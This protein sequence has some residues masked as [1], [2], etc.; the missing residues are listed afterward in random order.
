MIQKYLKTHP[1]KKM[2]LYIVPIGGVLIL[3]LFWFSFLNRSI[4][5]TETLPVAENP[6]PYPTQAITIKT[7]FN[8]S[9][10]IKEPVFP[11]RI[12]SITDFGAVGDGKTMN[13]NVFKNA[14]TSCAQ[15]GGGKV[16]VPAGVYLTGPIRLESNIE[17]HVERDAIILFSP[18]PKDYLPVVFSRFEGIEYY[19]YSPPIYAS[20]AT[21][22]AITGTGTLNGQGNIH[23][24]KIM[25]KAN[26][27]INGLYAMGDDNV[28]VEKRIFGDE[29][30]G[31][32]PAFIECI[33]CHHVLIENIKIINGPMWTIHPLYSDH[34]IVRGVDIATAPGPSTDGI[35]IDSSTFVLVENSTFNTG[36]D[37][38]VLKSGRD[39]DGWRVNRPTE[40]VVIRDCTIKE[41]HGAV[42]IGSE[43]SGDIRNVFGSDIT[44]NG[45][46]FGFRI[47]G[48]LGR[49]G[50]VENIWMQD[51][52]MRSISIDAVQI[53]TDYG[54][55]FNQNNTAPPIFRN[56]HLSNMTAQ[57]ASQAIYIEGLPDYP[58]E[59][60]TFQNITLPT[61]K[62]G[63]V[64]RD[65]REIHMDGMQ[66][67]A[68]KD[69]PLIILTNSQ[70]ISVQNT[71]CPDNITTCLSVHGD[72][73][74]NIDIQGNTYDQNR[75]RTT[76]DVRSDAILSEDQSL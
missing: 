44:I 25:A 3:A 63:I 54:Y 7:P 42:A 41:S 31:L 67:T 5:K 64:I 53:T 27:Y 38:I 32:R 2:K 22:V 73:S 74:L 50:V 8:D 62:D 51:F 66:I 75:I 21:N 30:K 26:K 58:I 15:A 6:D 10:V 71:P 59:N 47:K 35:A 23:W 1:W 28:P 4:P 13:T 24:W 49:G 48:A 33:N 45:S 68:K 14:I 65:A 18:S 76:T 16:I 19:N 11:D 61:T 60:I 43:M 57:K 69:Y 72:K 34:V 9:L 17:L 70:D 12:C 29:V 37:A 52:S 39:K 36:D 56:I 20:D 55:P 40:N 46:Q